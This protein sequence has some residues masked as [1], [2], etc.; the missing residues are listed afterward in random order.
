MR[1]LFSGLLAAL[2]AGLMALTLVICLLSLNAQP[3]ILE[4]PQ[5][6]SALAQNFAAALNQGDL[7]QAGAYIYG[8]PTLTAGADWTDDAK[9]QIWQAYT[10]SL[11]CSPSREPQATD[12]GI[13]W[14][15]EIQHLDITALM[16]AWQ[17]QTNARLSASGE[18]ADAQQALSDGLTQA[19]AA[20]Q[21]PLSQEL[22]LHLIF[23]DD[24]WW[25]SPDTTLLQ[26]LSGQ[27]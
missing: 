12:Q 27:V 7:D 22:T 4:F 21:T 11:R 23:R 9:E 10:G 6:A 14:T 15:V 16:N 5:Q 25:I 8:Q 26:L 2:G 24:Q 18:T 13:D 3:K 19:L 20:E 17:E 1:K